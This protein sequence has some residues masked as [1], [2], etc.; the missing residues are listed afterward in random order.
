MPYSSRF[1][2][3]RRITARPRFGRR[4]GGTYRRSSG[5][6]RYQSG[7]VRG[8]ARRVSRLSRRV[9]SPEVKYFDTPIVDAVAGGIPSVF[10]A[11]L[12]II[13]GSTFGDA[14]VG[15]KVTLT[16]I[17]VSG[18][19]QQTWGTTVSGSVALRMIVYRDSQPD[20]SIPAPTDILEPFAP[21]AIPG[22][23][24]LR[25][26]AT[27]SRFI[28]VLDQRI[29]LSQS[30]NSVFAINKYLKVSDN[31]TYATGS[32]TIPMTTTYGILL[33]NDAAVGT[34][35]PTSCDWNL[36]CRLRYTDN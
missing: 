27:R 3:R 34:P 31:L 30:G 22:T 11:D 15:N 4:Y 32:S 23:P 29:T 8:L 9:G 6:G 7:G 5:L 25:E 21:L 33:I 1:S 28:M 13:P 18:Y 19:V 17:Q 35:A 12:C 36:Q 26:M 14:R 20:A 16:S 24:S 10:I 2:R